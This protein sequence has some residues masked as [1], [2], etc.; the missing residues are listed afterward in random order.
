MVSVMK[1]PFC[2]EKGI[3]KRSENSKTHAILENLMQY[4][5]KVHIVTTMVREKAAT[6]HLFLISLS[7][8]T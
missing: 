6:N 2:L 1:M 3:C 8:D 5:A 4:S 7:N